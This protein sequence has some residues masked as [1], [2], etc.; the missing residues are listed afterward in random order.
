MHFV[1]ILKFC[2]VFPTD[3]LP[4]SILN[5]INLRDNPLLYV[6]TMTAEIAP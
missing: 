4:F 1:L 5:I 2:S 3:P 6:R